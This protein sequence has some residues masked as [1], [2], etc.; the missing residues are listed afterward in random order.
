MHTLWFL[1]ALW[2]S[3]SCGPTEFTHDEIAAIEAADACGAVADSCAFSALQTRRGISEIEFTGAVIPAKKSDVKGLLREELGASELNELREQLGEQLGQSSLDTFTDVNVTN[4]P[5]ADPCLS[6][7]YAGPTHPCTELC[8]CELA[9]NDACVSGCHCPQGC[10][11]V[12][13]EHPHSVSFKNKARAAGLPSTVI[14]TSPRAYYKDMQA[15]K[16]L[17]SCTVS[18]INMLLLD[19]WSTY[20]AH[21]KKQSVW[22]CFHGSN[23]A[24]VKYLHLQTFTADG[25]FHGMPSANHQVA[26]CVKMSNMQDSM[27]LAEQLAMQIPR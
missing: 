19:G 5:I 26:M 21:V 8:F 12:T 11:G 22:Q 27:S 14:L 17:A 9:G 3:A 25:T 2:T 7:A 13:W 23:I 6:I 18:I 10:E 4:V 20:Q 1:S 16:A 24:S 15:L